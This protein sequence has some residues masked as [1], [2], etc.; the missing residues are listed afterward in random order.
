MLIDTGDG[1]TPSVDTIDA[2]AGLAVGAFIV[3]RLLAFVPPV[4]AAHDVDQRAVDLSTL[5]F[6]YRAAIGALFV[7][8]TRDMAIDQHALAASTGLELRG[9]AFL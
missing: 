3:D 1:F 8:V 7:V 9:D 2:L 4:G 5:R 6:P